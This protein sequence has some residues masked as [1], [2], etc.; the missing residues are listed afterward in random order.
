MWFWQFS[1]S[2]KIISYF[3]YVYIQVELQSLRQLWAGMIKWNNNFLP[4][5]LLFNVE[6]LFRL[7]ICSNFDNRRDSHYN[8]W[9]YAFRYSESGQ[10]HEFRT[11]QS[12]WPHKKQHTVILNNDLNLIHLEVMIIYSIQLNSQQ[13]MVLN[14]TEQFSV[15]N[16]WTKLK[17]ELNWC[18]HHKCSNGCLTL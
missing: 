14:E 9:F 16:F 15:L 5:D 17:T 4:T 6:T 13:N 10:P 1:S 8:L 11:N 12:F 18:I 2:P 3:K 7:K